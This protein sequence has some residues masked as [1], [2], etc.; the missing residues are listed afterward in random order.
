MAT[1][2]VE[3]KLDDKDLK[4]IEKAVPQAVE[5]GVRRT[6]HMIEAA[7][8]QLAPEDTGNLVNSGTTHFDGSGY[9]TSAMIKF[10]AKNEFGEGYALAV[11]EGTGIFGPKKRRI[12]PVNAKALMIP[13][14]GGGV[15]FRKSVK[16]MP[17][18]PFLKEAFEIEGPKL[19]KRILE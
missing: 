12:R 15:V 5:R 17:G 13:L 3:L 1:P 2:V 9:Q 18:R 16:G 10:E 11:H 14:P 19:V 8:L 7:A 6:A 4:K